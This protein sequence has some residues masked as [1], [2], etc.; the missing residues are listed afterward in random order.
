[1]GRAYILD[2]ETTGFDEPGL[3]EVAWIKL[4]PSPADDLYAKS[5][6]LSRK[7]FNPGKHIELGA[8][9]VH[10][11]VD[12]DVVDC[13]PAAEFALPADL[14]YLVGHFVDFDWKAI[15]SPPVKRICTLLLAR[16]YI[17][18]APSFNLVALL[19]FLFGAEARRLA[20]QAHAALA[21]CEMARKL[22]V[23]LLDRMP[24]KPGSWE[25]L[26]ALSEVARNEEQARHAA[27]IAP[28]SQWALVKGGAIVPN[29]VRGDALSCWRQGWRDSFGD[30]VPWDAL[31][32]DP[33]SVRISQLEQMGYRVVPVEVSLAKQQE[34][35]K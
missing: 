6:G 25:D 28:I 2:C 21:D 31:A 4:A 7:R 32:G 1:M 11:I 8:T 16:K 12:E 29:A 14:A 3:I 34:R 23:A 20:R 30:T 33:A 13:P 17:P 18:E 15:G 24:E 19:Y 22:L 27:R 26:W 35:R 10:H 9:C 5:Y